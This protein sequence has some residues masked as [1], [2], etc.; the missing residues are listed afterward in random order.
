MGFAVLIN[1]FGECPFR[2]TEKEVFG[3]SVV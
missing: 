1:G 2:V 3:R